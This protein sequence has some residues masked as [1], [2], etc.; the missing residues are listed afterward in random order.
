MGVTL[1]RCFSFIDYVCCGE[2]DHSFPELVKRLERGMTVQD[3][4]GIVYREAGS[5]QSAGAPRGLTDMDALPFPN[6]DDY[7]SA[8]SRYGAAASMYPTVL[9]EAS[10]GCWWGAKI[11]CTFCGLNGTTIESR[12]KRAT[13]VLDE[14]AWLVD[15]YKASYVRMVDNMLNP[16]YFETL[17]P[18]LERRNSGVRFFF[19]I[20]P[21]LRKE[22]VKL[23]AAAGVSDIQAG[24][25]N[26][27]TDVL[28]FMKKGSSTISGIQTLKWC[29]QYDIYADWNIIFGFPGERPADYEK[30]FELARL[31][32]HLNPPAGIG[33]FRMDRFSTNFE[34]ATAMG[35]DD[36][37][38]HPAYRFVYPFS[39]KTLTDLVYFFDYRR[40]T[41]I[42]DGGYVNRL[43]DEVSGWRARQDQL[44]CAPNDDSLVVYDTRPVA[45]SPGSSL[46]GL[47]KDLIEYCDRA[48]TVDQLYERL[49]SE[50]DSEVPK[51]EIQQVLEGFLN[52][53]LMVREGS[54]YLSLPVMKHL[55]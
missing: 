44:T 35:F 47:H 28:R 16:E 18:E 5:S 15:R 40:R 43:S 49:K 53:K 42:D 34:Q 45:A 2:A 51:D 12:S 3:I 1:H 22:Q 41:K 33:P 26:L 36:V 55:A 9:V 30:N 4:P 25:E 8:L 27:S 17:L 31:L 13:R 48:H 50:R 52:D 14:I 7:F 39:E 6:Y 23:L 20:R 32:T 38:P 21:T 46:R 19:E 29:K 54:W 11:K 37:K 10:R 24:I